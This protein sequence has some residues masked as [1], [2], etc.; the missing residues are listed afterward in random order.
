VTSLTDLPPLGAW[1]PD[2]PA[3]HEASGARLAERARR[4]ALAG[5]DHE[6]ELLSDAARWHAARAQEQR[7]A[8]ARFR[9]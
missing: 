4:H 6:A 3:E 8:G 5:R 2:G 9:R 1:A 7:D